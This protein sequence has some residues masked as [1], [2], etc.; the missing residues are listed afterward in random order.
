[1]SQQRHDRGGQK[2]EVS[3]VRRSSEVEKFRKRLLEARSESAL[4]NA[5]IGRR[6]QVS[7]SQVGIILRGDFFSISENVARV[8][9]AIGLVSD[10]PVDLE[11]TKTSSWMRIEAK[12]LEIWDGTDESANNIII[13]L[14]TLKRLSCSRCSKRDASSAR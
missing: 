3:V 11:Q 12:I 1:V 7:R 5:E 14:D 8:G 4:S 10:V 13:L 2:E 6:A 9:K